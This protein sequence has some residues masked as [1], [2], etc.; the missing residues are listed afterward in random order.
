M[1]TPRV[2]LARMSTH[3]FWRSMRAWKDTI[4]P[5]AFIQQLAEQRH[6]SLAGGTR[7]FLIAMAATLWVCNS[8]ADSSVPLDLFSMKLE[9][10]VVYVIFAIS[11]QMFAVISSLISYFFINEFLRLAMVRYFK[12]DNAVAFAV[13]FEGTSIWS[14]PMMLQFRFLQSHRPHKFLISLSL[15]AIMLPGLLAIF[16]IDYIVIGSAWWTARTEF[17]SILN[18]V[19][20]L[21]SIFLT[22]F[23]IFYLALIFVPFKF[24]KNKRFIRWGFLSGKIHRTVMHPQTARWLEEGF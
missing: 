18:I 15:F 16:F 11:A 20:S 2:S 14:M 13:P 12:F 3:D 4:E 24:S 22:I 10:P 8:R 21:T 5:K 1:K 7:G 19:L 9:I 23:P 17:L 6:K